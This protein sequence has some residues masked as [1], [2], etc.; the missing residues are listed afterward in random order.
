MKYP[1]TILNLL[2]F[3]SLSVMSMAQNGTYFSPI[4]QLSAGYGM[5]PTSYAMGNA[6]RPPVEFGVEYRFHKKISVGLSYGLAAYSSNPNYLDTPIDFK[7]RLIAVRPLAHFGQLKKYDFYG[8][9]MLGI[10]NQKVE[11]PTNSMSETAQASM[12]HQGIRGN[13]TSVLYSAII[14]SKRYIGKRFLVF[15]EAG[16]GIS[17]LTAGLGFNLWK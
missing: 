11:I 9:L 10:L 13:K 5:V 12:K 17:M 15:A 4:V 6:T 2:V 8:G 16:F 1:I 7:S 14:G 3:T